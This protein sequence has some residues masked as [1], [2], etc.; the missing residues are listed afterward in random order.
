[1]KNY[2]IS[3]V[4][5][6][7]V[8][9]LSFAQ[10]LFPGLHGTSLLDSLVKYYKPPVVL[11]YDDARDKMYALIDNAR[12]SVT[13]V[14]TGY[15]VYVPYNH[16][17]PRDFTN[18]PSPIMNAEHSWPTSK[19]ASGNARSDLHHIYPTNEY[20]NSARGS[21]PFDHIPDEHATRWWRG[22]S[23]VTT[24][25]TIQ[26]EAYSKEQT[27]IRFEPRGDHKGNV[28][29]SMFYFYTMYK[30]EADATDPNFFPNQKD[31]LYAWHKTD[32]ADAGELDRTN[33]I[34][35]YQDGKPNPFII[36]S[37]LIQR[38][39]FPTTR[40]A[41]TGL[42]AQTP[43]EFELRQNY[44]N[45]FNSLTHIKLFLS[46]Q[47]EARLDII[48]MR[49]SLIALLHNGTIPAGEHDFLWSPGPE[50]ASGIY[51]YRLY[52]TDAGQMIVTRKMLL[53]K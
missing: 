53:I 23:Y 51:F 3:L 26:K 40:L 25:P 4:F 38:C 44:P 27:G 41:Q 48:D 36:D 34:A 17:T 2:L 18:T 28:A 32:P 21:L 10:S 20:A 13:C 30:S 7:T 47:A 14:Y 5:I 1:M 12:D 52:T 6:L 42:I 45:P 22:I 11:N 15:R 31:I 43:A 50:T 19:G 35:F 39:Y 8:S 29:R 37:T 16:P 9:T 33:M 49:G 24:I 46:R